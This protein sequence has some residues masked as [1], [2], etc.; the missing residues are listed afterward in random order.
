MGQGQTPPLIRAHSG[1]GV[2]AGE[3]GRD[4][5]AQTLGHRVAEGG[6]EFL[7]VEH[8]IAVIDDD[9]HS[10]TAQGSVQGAAETANA[11]RP[12]TMSSERPQG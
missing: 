12:R 9:D 10:R 11:T 5:A 3:H 6:E 4:R 1:P 8:R 7:D 2:R